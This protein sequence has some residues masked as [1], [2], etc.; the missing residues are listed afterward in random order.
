M[1]PLVYYLREDFIPPAMA[2][3]RDVLD[4]SAGLGDLSR[5]LA[6]SGASSVIATMPEARTPPTMA[7]MSDGLEAWRQGTSPKV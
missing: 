1:R 5:Y 3:G 6:E 7:A 2:A 4:C